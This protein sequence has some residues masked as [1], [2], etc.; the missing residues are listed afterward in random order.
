MDHKMRKERDSL[1]EVRVPEK[2]YYGIQTQRAIDNFPIS[3]LRQH[4]LMVESMV[5]IKKAAALSHYELG[6]LEKNKKDAVVRACDEILEGSLRDQFVVDVFQMGAGTSFHMNCN[7]LIANRAEEILGGKKGQYRL[8]HPNDHVNMGQSTNDVFPTSMR[9]AALFLLRKKMWGSL[10][11]LKES[12]F[13]KADEFDRILKSGRTHLQDAAPI[14]LGQEF[15]AYGKALE[16]SEHFLNHA[17]KSLLDLGIGG[18]A[19]GTG[20][21]TTPGYRKKVVEKLSDLTGFALNQAEDLREAMQSMRPFTEIASALRNV[22]VEMVRISNDLRL[23]SSGPNTGIAEIKLPSVAPGSSIMPGKVNPSILEMMNMV[24]YQVMGCDTAVMSAAHAGQLEVNVMMPIISFN[25]NLSIEI[26]G[27]ALVQVKKRC[28]EGIKVNPERARAYAE[29]STGIAAALSP[30]IGYRKSAE[31]AKEALASNKTI[32]QV[33]KEK[34]LFTEKQIKEILDP[35]KMTEPG[36]AGQK[37]RDED[38]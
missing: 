10:K 26:L 1:G 20:V 15:K 29:S 36:V 13:R 24:G 32:I 30:H 37:N 11:D 18:S 23:L 35:E 31:I 38:T 9:L 16:K 5:L 25:I 22:A 12:F 7:E 8:I 28:V 27:N 14:R 4:P 33:M 3:G 21:N 34:K 17:S 2:A 19:V 6:R